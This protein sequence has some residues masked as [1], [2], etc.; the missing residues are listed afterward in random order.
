MIDPDAAAFAAAFAA[1]PIDDA[2]LDHHAARLVAGTEDGMG[3]K[4]ARAE[5]RFWAKAAVC[6]DV[7]R[8]PQCAYSYRR[9]DAASIAY[10]LAV[11]ESHPAPDWRE[12]QETV[13]IGRLDD[14]IRAS[15]AFA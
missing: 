7:G 2:T 8:C 3:A 6:R 5:Y 14:T 12:F 11:A 1:D 15:V 9:I 10:D 13:W 4:E